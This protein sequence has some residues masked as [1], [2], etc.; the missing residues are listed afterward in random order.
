MLDFKYLL[1]NYMSIISQ[2]LEYLLDDV[3]DFL[4]SQN[5]PR[6]DEVDS[7]MTNKGCVHVLQAF[8]DYISEREKENFRCRRQDNQDSV[9][10]TT[11]HQVLLIFK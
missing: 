2:V 6:Q 9:T 8:V 4:S 10:L 11:I 1:V 5:V 3:T 7:N